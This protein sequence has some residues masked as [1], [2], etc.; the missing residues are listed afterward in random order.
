[1]VNDVRVHHTDTYS[2]LHKALL[3]ACWT[4]PSLR[5]VKSNRRLGFRRLPESVGLFGKVGNFLFRTL[6]T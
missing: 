4:Q 3:A 2:S 6:P 1:V 5:A